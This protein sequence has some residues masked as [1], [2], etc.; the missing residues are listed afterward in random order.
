[1]AGNPANVHVWEQGD[2]FIFDPEITYVGATHLPADIDAPL[3]AAWLPAGLMLGDPG[4][5]MPR[6]IDKTDLNAWQAKRFRVKYRNGKV[7]MNFSLYEDNEVTEFLIDAEN[8]PT[9]KS[10][11]VAI[12]FLDSDTGYTE[13]RIS[14]VKADLWVANDNHPEEPDARPVEVSLY[15]DSTNAIWTIQKGIPT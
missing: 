14:K 11:R 15:P 8:V 3:H 4:V 1:M 7:D 2:V 10:A 9:Q 13:R 5:E 6:D 12:V